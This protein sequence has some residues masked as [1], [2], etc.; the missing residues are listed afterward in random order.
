LSQFIQNKNIKNVY[1]L[2]LATIKRSTSH[3]RTDNKLSQ[4]LKRSLSY[5]NSTPPVNNFRPFAPE[6]KMPRLVER[7]P[8]PKRAFNQQ[9]KDESIYGSFDDIITFSNPQ[10]NTTDASLTNITNSFFSDFSYDQNNSTLNNNLEPQ[11]I[12]FE[13]Q[14]ESQNLS[15]SNF[16]E[17][18]QMQTRLKSTLITSVMHG[19]FGSLIHE[20]LEDEEEYEQIPSSQIKRNKTFDYENFE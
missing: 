18:T 17:N 10:F 15:T 19:F 6:L 12:S 20:E 2:N 13:T 4:N 5:N 7:P 1:F 14:V 3:D 16:D 8:K 9:K 11:D